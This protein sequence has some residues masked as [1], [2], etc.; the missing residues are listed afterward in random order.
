MARWV[1]TND[2]VLSSRRCDCALALAVPVP[3]GLV[4]AV[5]L[6]VAPLD[7]PANF[8]AVPP[9][10]LALPPVA[11]EDE[12]GAA[13]GF[14]E[15]VDPAE[16]PVADLVVPPLNPLPLEEGG[17]EP[18]DEAGGLEEPPEGRAA[19][20]EDG[21]EEPPADGRLPPPL[22]RAPPPERAPPPR[23]CA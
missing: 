20:L 18:E 4:P 11:W 17:F 9:E 1:S 16:D 10:G 14:F 8:P 5:A 22:G 12:P 15:E 19:P 13:G 23:R 3:V 2:R 21:R 6:G 7:P